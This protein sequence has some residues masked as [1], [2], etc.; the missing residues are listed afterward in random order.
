MDKHTLLHKIATES[1]IN[2]NEI[3]EELLFDS[4][5]LDAIR[6]NFS[7]LFYQDDFMK[8]FYA[9]LKN[10]SDFIIE[11]DFMFLWEVYQVDKDILQKCNPDIWDWSDHAQEHYK[12]IVRKHHSKDLDFI[13]S[14]IKKR[15]CDSSFL[16]LADE[17]VFNNEELMIE[18]MKADVRQGAMPYLWGD[19]V[20]LNS[21][22][23]LR[24]V[25]HV[26]DHY[27]QPILENEH[28]ENQVK[29]S[30]RRVI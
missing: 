10:K 2:F 6:E 20:L 4:N 16:M 23:F 1:A 21:I 28:I 29:E 30:I 7:D 12:S 25:I 13:L 27:L 9:H 22:D 15:G 11:E 19:R 8:L 5:V 3:P 24:K 18:A 26:S 17:S 14:G